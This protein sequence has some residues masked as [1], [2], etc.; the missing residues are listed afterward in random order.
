[1]DEQA[2]IEYLEV[3]KSID[4]RSLNCA[5]WKTL[6]T[7]M[8]PATCEQPWQILEIGAGIGTMVRRL[9]EWDFLR[10]ADYTAL[11][12]C[13]TFLEE[14]RRRLSNWARAMGLKALSEGQ[15]LR[16]SDRSRDIRINFVD[17]ELSRWLKEAAPQERYDLL[18][19]HAFLDLV[20]LEETLPGLM[21]CLKKDGLFYFTLNFDGLTLLE[22]PIEETLDE[23]ILSFYHRTMEERR[24]G[25]KP[26]AGALSGRRLLRA[27]ERAGGTLLRAGASDWVVHSVEGQYPAGEERFLQF[28]LQMVEEAL[29]GHNAIDPSRLEAWFGARRDQLQRGE[30]SLIVHQLDCVGRRR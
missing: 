21:R 23:G 16:I 4:D 13:A 22:P 9:M 12:A 20:N 28:F 30:L 2:F 17:A 7:A 25:E 29:R 5:V 14:G 15:R 8:P 11:D 24:A 10:Y 26:S 18:I 27:L 3:K 6:V 19:A 1:M